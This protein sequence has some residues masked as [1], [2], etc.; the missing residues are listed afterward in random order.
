VSPRRRNP[1][2]ALLAVA[3]VPALMLAGLGLWVRDQGATAVPP[4]TTLP[5]TTP[6][7]PLTTPLL[8][9]RRAPATLSR[10]V[11]I[12]AFRADAAAFLPLLNPTSCVDMSVDGLAVVEQAA[13]Q[14]F[15]PA[16]N[17]KLLTA[18]VAL[19]VLGA[20]FRYRTE[21]RGQRDDAGVVQGDLV[22]V[23][24]GDPNLA[25]AWWPETEVVRYPPFNV[26][27]MEA[28]ADQI[29]A[30]GVTSITG[31][32][33]GDGSRYDDEPFAPGV[34]DAAK[35]DLEALPV[36]GLVVNDMRTSPSSTANDPD[37]G[38]AIVL[39]RLLEERGVAV[40]GSAEAGTVQG[41]P[42]VITS[43]ESQPLPEVLAS[44]LTTSDN[45]AA[46]MIAKEIGLAR[47]GSGSWSAGLAEILAVVSSWGV[48][49]APLVLADGSGLSD[50]N[51]LTCRALLGVLQHGSV[52]D[53]IGNGL[54][55][56][57][58]PNGTLS[59]VF[60][61]TEMEGVLRAKTGT[62][63]NNDGQPDKPGV[64]SL[65]G[66]VPVEGGGAI[67]FALILNGETI[68]NQGE[69]RPVWDAFATL[70]ASYPSGPT[71][72]QLAPR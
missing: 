18:A 49:V 4:A 63:G 19:E 10:E 69:Y 37:T 48:D 20:D 33:V 38:A 7:P 64:K 46:D 72:E 23:G 61:G 41:D 27:S 42:P 62:L 66:Y 26:T 43:I 70:L 45:H 55:V 2:P 44:M 6:P 57:G 1:F 13:D 11:S 59:D 68:S 29:V 36:T 8:S 15:R 52:D 5:G 3:V 24:G 51:R 32:V 40:A 58:A 47:R 39:R 60:V 65:S 30:A 25:E 71:T 50:D 9:V 14:P 21:V 16:S 12:D 34:S 56:A 35:A 17:V 31:A 53:A 28:L 22:L 67:E 54:P